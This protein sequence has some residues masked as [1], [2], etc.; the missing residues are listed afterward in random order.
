MVGVTQ[1]QSVVIGECFV[2]EEGVCGF[3]SDPFRI[4][5]SV[6]VSVCDVRELVSEEREHKGLG[7][8]VA[9]CENVHPAYCASMCL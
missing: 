1:F 6:C 2:G 7:E 8:R 5:L 3:P 4:F 9:C